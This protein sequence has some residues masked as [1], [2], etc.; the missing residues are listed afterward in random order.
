MRIYRRDR[1]ELFT[2]TIKDEQDTICLNLM[3]TN[4]SEITKLLNKLFGNHTIGKN[5]TSI[6]IRRRVGSTKYE[7]ARFNLFDIK[8]GAILKKIEEYDSFGESLGNY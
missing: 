3:D 6:D 2:L 4:Q 1:Q 8:P 7:S 5:K